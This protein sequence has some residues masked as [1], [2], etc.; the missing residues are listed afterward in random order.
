M[1]ILKYEN[2]VMQIG[3][4][5][6]YYELEDALTL[7]ELTELY[8]TLIEQE[9]EQFKRDASL[10]GIDLDKSK[11]GDDTE[12]EMQRRF[13]EHVARKKGQRPSTAEESIPGVGYT[14][15]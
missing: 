2:K 1:D 14:Q 11:G 15:L 5:K 6:S 3:A 4:W 10:Q 12:K 7:D 9:N 13:R 8:G